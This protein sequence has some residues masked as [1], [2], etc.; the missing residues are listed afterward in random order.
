[1]KNVKVGNNVTISHY[2]NLYGC[3]LEDYVFIGPF[4]EI[5]SNVKL[6]RIVL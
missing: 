6:E 1:M 3:E 2:T 5:Q 4:V